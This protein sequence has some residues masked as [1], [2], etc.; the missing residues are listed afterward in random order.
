MYLDC[1]PSSVSPIPRIRHRGKARSTGGQ[2]CA[3]SAINRSGRARWS[4]NRRLRLLLKTQ[5]EAVEAHRRLTHP[6]RMCGRPQRLPCPARRRARGYATAPS[7]GSGGR[8]R[9]RSVRM[10]CATT[11][12]W[13]WSISDLFQNG[14]WARSGPFVVAAAVAYEARPRDKEIH[15][16]ARNS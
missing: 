8:G 1:R 5:P 15:R 11:K 10:R 14:Y 3:A 12:A 6:R 7:R 9:W 16:R 13:W 2:L 4:R